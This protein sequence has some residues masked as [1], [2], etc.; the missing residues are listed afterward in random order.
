M[1]TLYVEDVTPSQSRAARALLNLT[2]P[3]LA[4]TAK[5]GLSTV[6]DFERKRRQVSAEAIEAMRI[7]LERAGINFIDADGGGEGVRLRR[8]SA[9]R[10]R[11]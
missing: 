2:Q 11:K 7:A 5:L 1:S 10:Q 8:A 3:Q 6:V 9:A 4:R